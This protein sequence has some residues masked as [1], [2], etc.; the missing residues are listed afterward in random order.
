MKK[1]IMLL[2]IMFFLVTVML[3]PTPVERQDLYINAVSE[4]DP[5]TKIQLLKQYEQSYGQKQDQYLKFIYIQLAETYFQLK[6]YPDTIS[7]GEKALEW[8]EIPATNKLNVLY[9]LA[10]SYQAAQKDLQKAYDYAQSMIE[11]AHWVIDKAKN[12]ELEKDKLEQFIETFNKYYIGPGFRVQAM[13]MYSRGKDNPTAIKEAAQKAVDAYTVDKS[14]NSS[15]MAFSFANELYKLNRLDD[16]IEIAGKAFDEIN[17]NQRSAA[18]LATLHYKKG[19]KD[20]AV[21]YFELAYHTNKDINTAMK[22][23]QLV[24]KKDIDKGIQYFA[25]AYIMAHQDEN[26][27]AFK[28]LRQLYYREK[29]RNLPPQEQ[30]KG[31]NDIIQ[32]AK[33]RIEPGQLSRETTNSH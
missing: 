5:A 22:I 23:G 4:K 27:D 2:I 6:N 7:Y 26:S 21:H 25:D 15:R 19:D 31:F 13:I 11:L 20:K 30:E 1:V 8:E 24:Y 33:A 12:S 32:A 17:P 3:L 14:E 10:N 16:A 9:A 18:F 28:F 29:A